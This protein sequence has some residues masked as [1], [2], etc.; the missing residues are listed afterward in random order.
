MT[1]DSPKTNRCLPALHPRFPNRDGWSRDTCTC[2][3]DC[4]DDTRLCPSPCRRTF[5]GVHKAL[6]DLAPIIPQVPSLRGREGNQPVTRDS[7][8]AKIQP[9]VIAY[10]PS[11]GH[12]GTPY[13]EYGPVFSFR[14]PRPCNPLAPCTVGTSGGEIANLELDDI[15]WRSS[16]IVIRGKGR[17][18]NTLPLLKDVGEALSLYLRNGRSASD[19]RRV[20]LRNHA[21]HTGFA[22]PAAIGH[23]ARAAFARTDVTASAV[24]RPPVPPQPSHQNDPLWGVGH[25]DRGGAPP[26]FPGQHLDLCQGVHR[27]ASWCRSSVACLGGPVMSALRDAL[28][29]YISL[30]RALGTR[31]KEPAETLGQFVDFIEKEG[32]TFITTERAI[33]WATQHD[34]VQHNTWARRLSMVR[35]FASWLSTSDPR[36]EIPP[37]GAIRSGRTRRQSYIYTDDETGRLMA[38][39]PDASDHGGIHAWTYTTLL[40]LLASTGLRP[41]EALALNCADVDLIDAILTVRQTKFGKS[42]LVPLDASTCTALSGYAKER[43]RRCPEPRSDAFLVSERVSG[44]WAARPGPHSSGSP[45]VWG[46]GPG[47]IAAGMDTGHAFRISDIPLRRGDSSNGIVQVSTWH[48]RCL[49]FPPI[50]AMS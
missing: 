37:K 4:P 36:T 10:V 35:G 6:G 19:S 45:S 31:L 24:E 7:Y 15:R 43:N 48:G 38:E 32:A 8:D 27:S 14:K 21:P 44:S 23:I 2:Q 29:A 25:G 50:L 3:M 22:G 39:A 1:K 5:C 40:G 33:R 30:R 9:V 20:F 13:Q 12:G 11:C 28:A 34:W 42:R 16:E 17:R 49:R 18:I 26:S 41:G 47:V 46:C